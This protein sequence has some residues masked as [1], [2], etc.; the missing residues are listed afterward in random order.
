MAQGQARVTQTFSSPHF[1]P[2]I[3]NTHSQNRMK[4]QIQKPFSNY[5]VQPASFLKS[6]NASP[7]T[8]PPPPTF[9]SLGPQVNAY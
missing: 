9:N 7:S 4:R 3:S 5:M 6:L 1:S 2:H 8:K